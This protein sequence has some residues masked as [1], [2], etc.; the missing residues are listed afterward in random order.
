MTTIEDPSALSPVEARALFRAGTNTATSGWAAGH[1]QANLISVPADWAYDV[2][3]F[4]QR[5]PQPCPVLDVTDSGSATTVLAPTADLR[6]DLPGYRVWEHGALV[7]EPTDVTDRWRTDLV[8]FLIGCSFTFETAL[9]QAGVTLRHIEQAHNVAMYL[10]NRECRPAGRLHGQLVV[11]M[12][13]IPASQV[14]T[15]IR[16]TGHMPAVHG[17]PVH[18]GAP[19]A[20]GIADLDHPDFGDRI[21][22]ATG[23][24][25]V[26]WACGVTI[27]SALMASHPPFAITHAPGHMFITD[28]PDTDYLVRI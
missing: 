23:D 4:A 7:D 17:A 25:P 21:N 8:S 16:V 14:A 1:T 22:S 26:F 20:L 11:S 5:N 10:T 9:A 27:Q 15:A 6:T 13:P 18:T 19:A 24:V 28:V 3:L 12:R 2:L